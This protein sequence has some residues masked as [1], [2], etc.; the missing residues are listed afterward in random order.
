MDSHRKGDLTEA[1]VVVELKQRGVPVALPFGDNERYDATIET[2]SGQ[3]L[4]AQIKTGWYQDGVVKFKG[5][6]QHTNSKGNIR[7]PYAGSIDCFLV[8]SHEVERLF[9]VWEGEVGKNMAIRI[10]EPK[11]QHETTNWA[12]EYAFDSRWP[13]ENQQVRSVSGNRSPAV[14]PVG[15]LLQSRGIPFIQKTDEDHHLVACGPSGERYCLRACSGSISGGRI[16]FP[17]LQSPF[18]DAYCVHCSE[19]EEIYLVPDDAFDQSFSLRVEAPD[20]PD[21]S[22]NW[23]SDYTFDERWPP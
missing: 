16:R 7:K 23:A 11:Q 13:P 10:E 17:T 5:Y 2:P 1:T 8:Y 22:I 9:L 19:A 21:A 18:I 20:Q 12:E 6:S 4:R 3:L 14:K 15:E